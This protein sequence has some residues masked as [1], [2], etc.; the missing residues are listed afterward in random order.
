[1]EKEIVFNTNGTIKTEKYV[2]SYVLEKRYYMSG[3]LEKETVYCEN[4]NIKIEKYNKKN[5]KNVI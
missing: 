5:E 3:N 1:M 2:E 4:G